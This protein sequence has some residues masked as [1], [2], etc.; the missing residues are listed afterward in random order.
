MNTSWNW[1]HAKYCTKSNINFKIHQLFIET[2]TKSHFKL[3]PDVQCE[4][5]HSFVEIEYNNNDDDDEDDDDAVLNAQM[6]DKH[7]LKDT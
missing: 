5:A 4:S 3:L 1:E 2:R 6:I 7:M